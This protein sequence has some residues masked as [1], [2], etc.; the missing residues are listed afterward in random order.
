MEI[1]STYIHK[2]K[3]TISFKSLL[4]NQF[5]GPLPI[6]DLEEWYTLNPILV[7]IYLHE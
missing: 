5:I 7:G 4:Y 3:D 2:G 1:E 6:V